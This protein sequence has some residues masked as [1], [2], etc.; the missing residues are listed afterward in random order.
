[1]GFRG[2]AP[3]GAFGATAEDRRENLVI[4]ANAGI[5]AWVLHGPPDCRWRDFAPLGHW[6]RTKPRDIAN[7]V[8][9]TQAHWIPAFAGMTS[10]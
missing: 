3:G 9:V 2:G 5:H 4:P 7:Q 10:S 1:M 6:W 8:E